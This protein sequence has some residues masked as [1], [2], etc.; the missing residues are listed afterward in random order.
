MEKPYRSVF[1]MWFRV[2]IGQWLYRNFVH[3]GKFGDGYVL[4]KEQQCPDDTKILE[5]CG[6]LGRANRQ[7]DKA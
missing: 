2:A 5:Y 1:P 6:A 4:T 3:P 7:S